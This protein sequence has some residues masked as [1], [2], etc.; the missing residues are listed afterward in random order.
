MY[1]FNPSTLE[2]EAGRRLS[3]RLAGLQSKIQE[4]GLQRN[5]VFKQTNNKQ[6]NKAGYINRIMGQ[7]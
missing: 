7:K 3:S 4:S 2:A 1:T 5:S 6:I